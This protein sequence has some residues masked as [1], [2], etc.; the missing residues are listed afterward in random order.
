[1]LE[2]PTKPPLHRDVWACLACMLVGMVLATLP[3]LAWAIE[4]GTPDYLADGDDVYYLTLAR[5]PYHGEARLRDPF[6]PPSR[7]LPSLYSNLQF[8]PLS[9]LAGALGLP[10]QRVGL[11][12]RVVGGLAMGFSIYVLFRR[13]LRS[14]RHPVAFALGCGVVFLADDGVITGRNLIQDLI[15]LL[16]PAD[17]LKPRGSLN[18]LGL[19]RIVTPILNLQFLLLLA[20]ALVGTRDRVPR[21]WVVLGMGCLALCVHFYFFFWTAAVVALGGLVATSL[22]AALA[23]RQDAERRDAKLVGAKV[24]ALVLVGGMAL[25]TPQILS[26]ARTFSSPEYKPIL[27]RSQRGRAI[28]AG[29]PKRWLYTRFPW[30]WAHAALGAVAVFALGMGLLEPIWWLAVAGYAMMNSALVTGLEFENFHWIYVASAFGEVLVL[31]GLVLAVD[32]WWP[33]GR[34]GLATLA[35]VPVATLAMG[36]AW[37]WHHALH[38]PETLDHVRALAELRPLQPDLARLG[39][40]RTLVGP[41]MARVALLYSRSGMLYQRNQS[42]ISSLIPMRELNER[43]ALDAWLRGLDEA[44]YREV[45]RYP[46]FEV[47]QIRA[48]P[49]LTADVLGR[50]RLEIFGEIE[51]DPTP[52]LDR[53]HPDAFLQPTA[54]PAPRRGGPWRLVRESPDWNLWTKS[55]DEPPR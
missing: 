12:W 29:E 54:A 27:E 40:E 14:T 2:P 41:N 25:G 1:M 28:D 19:Y 21:R 49:E 32:R 50:Q 5:A 9:K 52:F 53:Y 6:V 17:A 45:A 26:N 55:S 18:G 42:A 15:Y 33:S 48:K 23:W 30:H 36:F 20:A 44:D 3:H 8:V 7:D 47:G 35:I 24:A 31:G 51:R 37:R 38:A 39:P 43:H 22:A 16:T 11:L 46:S 13:L 34:R 4:S 10:P